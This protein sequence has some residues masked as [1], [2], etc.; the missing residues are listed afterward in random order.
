MVRRALRLIATARMRPRLLWNL[1]G[2]AGAI[3]RAVRARR[4]P[5]PP[6]GPSRAARPRAHGAMPLW[7]QR[8]SACGSVLDVLD[9]FALCGI[10]ADLHV[11]SVLKPDHG[12]FCWMSWTILRL[13]PWRGG[14]GGGGGKRARGVE[15]RGAM[16]N[17]RGVLHDPH[18]Y[19]VLKPSLDKARVNVRLRWGESDTGHRG[20]HALGRAREAILLASSFRQ[21][22]RFQV[23]VQ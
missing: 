2:S 23:R 5:C 11:Y 16:R 20:M 14:G 19:S 7:A 9:D 8:Q 15:G 17:P 3:C 22:S 21:F 12:R 6:S 4:A 13:D 18:V 10:R 1:L